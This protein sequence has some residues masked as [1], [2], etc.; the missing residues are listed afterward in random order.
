MSRSETMESVESTLAYPQPIAPGFSLWRRQFMAIMWNTMARSL[1][2]KRVMVTLVLISLPMLFITLLGVLPLDDGESVLRTVGNA[3]Y[4]F[5]IIYSTFIL[6]AVLYLGNAIIF[7]QLIRGE[8][9]DSSIHFALLTPVRREILVLG[10]FTGGLLS[11]FLL[12]GGATLVSYLLLYLPLGMNRLTLDLS[13]GVALE[14][15]T[16]YLLM[17]FLACLGYGSVFMATGFIF[18]NPF[19]P[20]IGLAGWEFIN[21]LMPPALKIISV[22]YYLK[23]LMPVSINEGPLPLAVVASPMPAYLSVLGIVVIAAV[24][25]TISVQYMRRMQVNYANE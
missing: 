23:N 20:V 22:V 21:F 14:Q 1:L 5:A 10:R 2:S 16:A 13:G 8:I 11:T 12:F 25:L 15:I 6:A 24:A 17:T 9:L 4:I 3:R 18:R 19:I 7:T